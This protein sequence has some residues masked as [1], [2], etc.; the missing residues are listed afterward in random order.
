MIIIIIIIVHYKYY[1]YLM[2]LLLCL[3]YFHHIS[4]ILFDVFIIMNNI[5]I[6]VLLFGNV[7]IIW[8]CIGKSGV[9]A[10]QVGGVVILYKSSPI[11]N[12]S[13]ALCV[14]L[15]LSVITA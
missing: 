6:K 1:Q 2:F 15:S 3:I 14:S 9:V 10:E 13:D 11:Q 12:E 7:Y 8:K 4:L 5:C